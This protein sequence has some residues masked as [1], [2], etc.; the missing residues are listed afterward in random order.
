[1]KTI[2]H[3]MYLGR[4][5]EALAN[6]EKKAAKMFKRGLP[7]PQDYEVPTCTVVRRFNKKIM[8]NDGERK[9]IT[10]YEIEVTGLTIKFEEWTLIGKVSKD[11]ET[12][13]VQ[14]FKCTGQE[15]DHIL[16]GFI[17]GIDLKRCDHCHAKRE[18]NLGF[19][20]LNTKDDRVFQVGSS[21][22]K[23]FILGLDVNM[24]VFRSMA[25]AAFLE[26]LEEIEGDL[27][28]QGSNDSSCTSTD[29]FLSAVHALVRESGRFITATEARNA[30]GM[31]SSIST[32]ESAL[33]LLHDLA[34]DPGKVKIE[35]TEEDQEK[36]R[37]LLD[38]AEAN[39]MD[40]DLDSLSLFEANIKNALFPGYVTS[41]TS[42]II[43]YLAVHHKKMTA[44]KKVECSGFFGE[45]KAK[46]KDVPMELVYQTFYE[47]Q[48]GV[49]HVYGFQTEDNHKVVW[50]ASSNQHIEPG[51]FIVSGTVKEHTTYNGKEQTLILRAKVIGV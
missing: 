9:E 11:E 17:N 12:G 6:M 49:T 3:P 27:G 19:I 1:M 48:Y 42:G 32:A 46:F 25:T 10:L 22:L 45:P 51:K 8:T 2:I 7:V 26:M 37:I 34:K 38:W 40:K 30:S 50:K 23:D 14:V 41:K 31:H 13:V 47:T 29:A 36:T 20:L 15:V 24:T 44:P 28:G 18:R 43:A 4:I 35:I 33:E 5:Q 39:I 16:K 21:C